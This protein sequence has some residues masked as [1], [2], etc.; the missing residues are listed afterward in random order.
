MS[1]EDYI[2]LTV[3]FGFACYTGWRAVTRLQRHL[4]V[5]GQVLSHIAAR[6]K[7]VED[8]MPKAEQIVYHDGLAEALGISQENLENMPVRALS[9][10]AE[11][12][13]F[14]IMI[15]RGGLGPGITARDDKQENVK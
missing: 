6:I 10:L 15:G 3:I 11:R 12:K 2:I 7:H 14:K 8:H 4:V 5:L 9:N 13:G 1:A